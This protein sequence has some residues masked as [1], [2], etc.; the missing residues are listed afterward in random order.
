MDKRE[1]IGLASEEDLVRITLRRPPLNLL[2][3]EMLRQFEAHLESLG[4]S[5][6]CRAL[7]IEAEG[8][9]FSG[10]IDVSERTREGI[11]LLLEQFHR[12]ALVIGAFPRP[13]IALVRGMAL[14]AG[15][16]LVACCDFVFATDKASFGQ[17]E[18]KVGGMPSLASILLPPLIGHRRSLEMILTGKLLDAAGAARVGLIHSVVA[19]DRLQDAVEELVSM[20]RGLSLPVAEVALR[21]ARMARMSGLDEQIRERE[22]LYLDELMELEDSVEGAKAFIEKRPPK[23][24]NQ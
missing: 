10:G 1:M 20:L 7:V 16:E 4:D 15:N 24:K 8:P 19:E 14:G 5:P 9:A 17:P 2:N 13:T 3:L 22:A 11:F 6:P 12:V 23:W 21:S 18:I